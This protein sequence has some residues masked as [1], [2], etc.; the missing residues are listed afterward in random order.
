MIRL[1]TLL[2]RK[3]GTTHQ[4]FL[5][6]WFN[7]HGP[8]I[9]NGSA[10]KYVR[11]YEQ[12]PAVWPAEGSRHEPGFDG[13]TIQIFDSADQFNAHMG[14][15]D[16]PLVMEDTE[17]FLDTSNIQWILTEEPNLVIDN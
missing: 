8:L 10:A 17:K 15:P 9:K 7:T 3:P 13:V 16:F 5:D 12:H 2:K 11:R 1:V 14:E 6:Y 4:E